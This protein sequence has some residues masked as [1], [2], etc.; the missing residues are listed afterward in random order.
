M[1][2]YYR[3]IG[4][5]FHWAPAFIISLEFITDEHTVRMAAVPFSAV[6]SHGHLLRE[7]HRQSPCPF[8]RVFG[9]RPRKISSTNI[10]DSMRFFF[11]KGFYFQTTNICWSKLIY[12][13]LGYIQDKS[14]ITFLQHCN[15]ITH[16][17]NSA[18]RCPPL[19]SSTC[20]D[21]C[22]CRAALCPPWRPPW[23]PAP[24]AE[25]AGGDGGR[26]RP[27]C[28]VRAPLASAGGLTLAWP[29]RRRPASRSRPLRTRAK[30]RSCA[31]RA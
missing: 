12:V 1:K 26:G 6:H 27:L 15:F 30:L 3:I 9:R 28:Y 14:R 2:I 18:T 16:K 17:K 8:I 4:L 25:T 7:T 13:I 31:P 19:Y 23:R 10:F 11:K 24:L 20:S 22:A 29:V 5:K 21:A